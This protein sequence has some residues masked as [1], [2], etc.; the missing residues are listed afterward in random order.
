MRDVSIA[1]IGLT[2]VGEHWEISLRDLAQEAA[3]EALDNAGTTAVDAIYVANALAGQI[4]RQ[5]HLGPLVAD[6]LGLRGV[7]AIRVEAADASGGMALRQAYLAVAS[8]AIETALVVGVEK[9]TDLVASPRQS[10]LASSLDA[11]FEAEQGATPAAMA[12]LIMQ[13][14]LYEYGLTLEAFAGFSENAHAN[15]ALNEHAMYRNRLRPGMFASAPV[16]APP[17]GLF[18]A[19]PEGDGAAALVIS[20]SEHARD[21]GAVP[22]RIVASAAASDSLAVQDR[23]NPLAL[24]AARISARKAFQQAGLG[25]DDIDLFELHDSFT[26]MAALSLEAAGFAETGQGHRMARPE[27]IG[28]GGSL[29]IG[30]FGGLKARGNPG[31]ATGVYQAVEIVQQLRGVAGKN[32]VEGARIGMAQNLGA[33]GGT[34]VTHIFQP[35]D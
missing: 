5:E 33:M 30:T 28:L 6:V 23:A 18:D 24:E 29:P 2:P 25:P 35:L 10:A 26:I 27:M 31:G 16:V 19:A 15:G 14:Y 1:G 34:A 7:E 4:S 17:V 8:G 12:A 13:R 22:V 21:M 20:S 11:E 9:F 32:Q 3:S